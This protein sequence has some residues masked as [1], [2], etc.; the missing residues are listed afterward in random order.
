MKRYNKPILLALLMIPFVSSKA[1]L[2]NNGTSMFIDD[3]A[4]VTVDHTLIGTNLSEILNKG[5][6]YVSGDI[7]SNTPYFFNHDESTGTLIL[8]GKDQNIQGS[9]DITLHNMTLKNDHIKT[10]YINLYVRTHLAL[11]SSILNL[12]NTAVT[13]INENENAISRT[14]GYINTP[15]T[16]KLIR[17]TG[18][19]AN[20][21]LF[22][23]GSL[24]QK[25][26]QPVSIS[27][28]G[29]E[30]STFSVSL[31]DYTPTLSG[32]DVKLKEETIDKVNDQFYYA[33]DRLSGQDNASLN[34]YLD[35]LRSGEYY[36]IGTW[37]TTDNK[38][39]S[40]YATIAESGTYDVH[41]NRA[42]HVSYPTFAEKEYTLVKK[43]IPE[44][45]AIS[46]LIQIP[47]SFTPNND[48]LNDF[49]EIKGIEKFTD[50][51]V[52]IFNRWGEIIFETNGYS[53]TNHFNALDVMQ[54]VYVYVVEVKSN[55]GYTKT[56]HG[57]LTILR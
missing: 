55:Q 3:E 20:N 40:P 27:T 10:A 14:A 9:Y 34:F 45:L 49:W 33:I 42:L 6:L 43:L 56:Y 26:Y 54:G 16:A 11:N 2:I 35:T 41:L 8:N 46:K 28:D 44:T 17:N 15:G 4:V 18:W 12:Q 48:G 5:E 50:N 47:N 51:H 7:I 21:Y 1:Q 13:I 19:I 38:W 31:K 29:A 30:Q 39:T 32:L 57:D 53:N 24:S 37:N 36:H 25:Y 23:V 52:A 22:P